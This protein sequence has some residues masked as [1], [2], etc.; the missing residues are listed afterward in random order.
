MI[1]LNK[2]EIGFEAKPLTAPIEIFIGENEFWGVIGP[3][4]GGKTTLLKTILGL[5]PKVS[6][7]LNYSPKCS[8]GY[9]PQHKSF[10]KLFPIS[11]MELVLM[12][13]YG[14]VGF[15]KSITKND[16]Q[17]AMDCLEKVGI[18]QLADR[19]FRSLSGGEIQRALIARALVGEP[20][21]VVLDEP[22]VSVDIR[23]EIE[24][25]DLVSSIQVEYNL[26]VIMVSHYIG[27]VAEYAE[28][29]ILIDKDSRVFEQGLSAD[30]V[31]S[32]SV[33]EIFGMNISIGE[34]R[35]NR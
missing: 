22:T 24:I 35:T 12:G 32:E 3:N 21:V 8:F 20:S 19:T 25:M 14:K 7:E 31:N 26:T 11:V 34:K 27:R 10:D 16:K 13:R 1:T 15:G 30:I 23:G 9:V 5:L 33:K 28:R 17:I 6:G 4:G 2:V 18:Y 29:L